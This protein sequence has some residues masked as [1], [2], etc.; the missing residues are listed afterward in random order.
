MK[1]PYLHPT[2]L[3]TPTKRE[4]LTRHP[5]VVLLLFLVLSEVIE[6]G[7][8]GL[9]RAGYVWIPNGKTIAGQLLIQL[10]ATLWTVICVLLY[11]LLA[12]RRTFASLGLR[13][14][15]WAAEYGVGLVGG[16][17]MFGSA[18]LLTVVTGT[19]TLTP[20]ESPP[21]LLLLLLFFIGFL[22]QG[23]SEE[24]MC[25]S[26]LMISLSRKLPLWACVTGNALLFSILHIGNPN[27][28]FI[29]L[30]N[31]FLFG[32]FASV[33]TLRRGSIWMI[34]ALHSMWNFAQGNLFGIP[35]SGLT[36]LPSPLTASI[37]KGEWQTLISGGAF[38]LEG[39]LAVTAVLLISCALVIFLPGF[40]KKSNA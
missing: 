31:I 40:P 6:L 36:G 22:I 12:E 28:S 20:A 29:A 4:R 34:G 27:I 39:G 21:S 23:M 14:R 8:R 1:F 13:G 32:V 9:F 7:R 17:T 37:G 16:F 11:C 18:V 25:R 19:V 5:V 30:L 15:F 35:V 24:L 10:F 3:L 2:D 33:L 38:G 26:Y